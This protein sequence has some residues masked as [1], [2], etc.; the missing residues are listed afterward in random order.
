MIKQYLSL[1]YFSSF[2]AAKFI[3]NATLKRIFDSSKMNQSPKE[4]K[5]ATLMNETEKNVIFIYFLFWLKND[6]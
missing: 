3:E 1:I 6:F 4:P 2:Y 5:R